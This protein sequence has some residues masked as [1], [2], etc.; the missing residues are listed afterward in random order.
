MATARRT[1]RLAQLTQEQDAPTGHR[2]RRRDMGR[3][4]HPP[5]ALG[6]RLIRGWRLGAARAW[7]RRGG[8]TGRGRR[9]PTRDARLRLHLRVRLCLR[10]RRRAGRSGARRRTQPQNLSNRD[11]IVGADVVPTCQLVV[12]EIVPPRDAVQGVLRPHHVGLRRIAG[13]RGATANP[14]DDPDDADRP[15]SGAA[16][17]I[18][19]TGSYRCNPESSGTKLTAPKQSRCTRVS[20][21]V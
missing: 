19:Q 8:D 5:Q 20:V 9:L 3:W 18:T 14:A 2:P 16:T 10:L 12:V 15:G 1:H 21:L 17:G 7:S 4:P 11:V 13:L 6:F